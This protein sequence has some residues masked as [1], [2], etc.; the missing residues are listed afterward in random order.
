[1]LIANR[2]EVACRIARTARGL[3]I[4]TVGV[5]APPDIDS[6]HIDAVETAVGVPDYMDGAAI[7][8]AALA[9]GADAVHPGFGFLAENANFASL[10]NAA[11]LVWVGPPPAAIESM[12]CK[13]GARDMMAA[14]GVPVLPGY[15]GEAQDDATLSAEAERI[16]FP[17]IV[18][19]SAGGG[20]KGM[21]VVHSA[22]QLSDAL[23]T[24]RRLAGS[25]FG[26]ERLILERY[27]P[28]AR[29]IEVQVLADSHGN[30]VHLFERECSIQRRHQKV[31][32]EA[33]S[34]AFAECPEAR[35]ALFE[36]A[37]S[38]AQAVDYVGAGT[39]EFVLDGDGQ[40]YFLEMNTRL[41]VEHPVT[42]QVTGLDIVALQLSVAEGAQLPFVQEEILCKGW[43]IEAR[44]YAEDPANDDLPSTGLIGVWDTPELEGLRI[45]SGVQLGSQVGIHYDPMLAKLI[46]H[47][48]T[49]ATALRKLDAGLD[50]L[51]VLGVLTNRHHLRR[52][53]RHPDFQA[54]A[55]STRFLEHHAA[56]LQPTELPV[57]EALIAAVTHHWGAAHRPNRPMPG[58][59]PNWRNNRWRPPSRAYACGDQVHEVS[60]LD[61]G[62]HLSF[63][64]HE[65][66]ILDWGPPLVLSI[67]GTIR[68]Y[69]VADIGGETWV[70]TPQL[71]VKLVR[72]P[73]FVAPGAGLIAGGCTAPM[74]GKIVQICVAEGEAVEQGQ[75]LVVLEAMK[76]EQTLRAPHAGTVTE[77]R[78][79]VG[80]QVDGGQ[81]LLTLD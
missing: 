45:D 4:R 27:L 76:M 20:G 9:E 54:G 44:L 13:A 79:S 17:V 73:D 36:H 67:D 16:G 64:D 72:L 30:Y 38:A 31:I 46:A 59:G 60:W 33:P 50:R 14:A 12:G 80:E 29:H 66:G 47:G 19:P 48:T 69:T 53:L 18:K 6:M 55:L 23:G 26:D 1:L 58:I 75:A 56:A 52:I 68:R 35:R 32:E 51:V 8:R 63:G 37:I 77:L 15:Q 42:E 40:P 2:G 65:V 62:S 24:A 71:E 74:P 57:G 22:E 39:V 21:Q 28:V 70:R 5:F 11:G 34:P 61:H 49:R 43:S 3:G 25:A 78:V 10:V 41:Q 81:S 7:V